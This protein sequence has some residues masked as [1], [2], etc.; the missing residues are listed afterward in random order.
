MSQTLPSDPQATKRS[1]VGFYLSCAGVAIGTT[2]ASAGWLWFERAMPLAVGSCLTLVCSV[3]CYTSLK[4][5]R[6]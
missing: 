5:M 3:T 4:H 2:V 6:R 1:L